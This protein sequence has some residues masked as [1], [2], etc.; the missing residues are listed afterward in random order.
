MLDPIFWPPISLISRTWPPRVRIFAKFL[1]M[2]TDSWI[3]RGFMRFD[4]WTKQHGR[5]GIDQRKM[6]SFEFGHLRGDYLGFNIV[7]RSFVMQCWIWMKDHT[8]LCL[9]A[10]LVATH[11]K[12]PLSLISRWNKEHDV[13]FLT[14]ARYIA[15]S[16]ISRYLSL[17]P[18]NRDILGLHCNK[19]K[20]NVTDWSWKDVLILFIQLLSLFSESSEIIKPGTEDNFVEPIASNYVHIQYR[21]VF[22]PI[23]MGSQIAK[24]MGPTRGPPGS[25]RPQ[26]GPMWAPWTLLSGILLHVI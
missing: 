25:C 6:H 13:D 24:F 3:Y 20:K 1:E 5:Q 21:N 9:H 10:E 2:F 18:N 23:S 22:L 16:L 14:A 15:L 8:T 26:M 4:L 17:D 11:A 19:M 12:P 7:L